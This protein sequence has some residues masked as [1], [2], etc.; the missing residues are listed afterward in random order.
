MTPVLALAHPALLVAA[1]TSKSGGSS[2]FLIFLLVIAVAGYFLFLR[3]QQQKARKQRQMQSDINEGD[4]VVTVGGIVGRVLKME[5]DRV[6]LVT[7]YHATPD[8]GEHLP[9]RMTFVRNAI[10]RKVEPPAPA[11]DEGDLDATDEDAADD[12]GYAGNGH[13]PFDTAF[14]TNGHGDIG[15]A[16]HGDADAIAEEAGPA[17]A[18][19][20]TDLDAD[21]GQ[22]GSPG[23][24]AP[25][26]RGRRAQ[27]GTREGTTS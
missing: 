2:T 7:G 14:D 10:S 25:R 9:H 18:G 27:G 3:P 20:G 22:T 21:G 12:V 24:A 11:D 4:E 1:S 6:H 5:G 8:L 26:R 17:V 13:G 15:H 19:D 16:D 23:T